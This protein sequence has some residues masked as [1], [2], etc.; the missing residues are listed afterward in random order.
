[1]RAD[2]ADV[3]WANCTLFERLLHGAHGAF[4]IRVCRR[5][6][7]G[8]ARQAIT[9]DLGVNVRAAS[10]CSSQ[11]LEHNHTRSL[12]RYH[13][14]PVTI[15]RLADFGCDCAELSKPCVRDA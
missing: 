2:I 13:S 9:T 11:R 8:I 7:M 14:L 3:V 10:L 4:A 1:M 5:H 6:V 15:K 12:A